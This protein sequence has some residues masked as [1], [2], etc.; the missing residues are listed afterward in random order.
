MQSESASILARARQVRSTWLEGSTSSRALTFPL[1]PDSSPEPE[2]I[3]EHVRPILPKATASLRAKQRRVKPVNAQPLAATI[4]P[5]AHKVA[6]RNAEI[7]THDEP[8]EEQVKR[9]TKDDKG[10]SRMA[11]ERPTDSTVLDDVFG[12]AETIDTLNLDRRRYRRSR[13][14]Q[15]ASTA[16]KACRYCRYAEPARAKLAEYC[17]GA[18]HS[19]LCTFEYPPKT[20]VRDM[21]AKTDAEKT[22]STVRNRF[23]KDKVPDPVPVTPIEVTT[24]STARRSGLTSM[25]LERW[26]YFE[27]LVKRPDK[28]TDRSCPYCRAS[29][30]VIR[31]ENA[32]Y[33]RG[34]IESKDCTF[35][36]HKGNLR[37][38]SKKSQPKEKVTP[39]QPTNPPTER[40]IIPKT[41]IERTTTPKTPTVPATGPDLTVN[42][43]KLDI[44]LYY[45]S[46][47]QSQLQNGYRF[48]PDCARSDD[49]E[50]RR[51]SYWC[52]GRISF[53]A[54]GYWDGDKTGHRQPGRHSTSGSK[55]KTAPSSRTLGTTKSEP[56]REINSTPTSDQRKHVTETDE[57]MPSRKRGRP[58]KSDVPISIRT[59]PGVPTM[60]VQ[61]TPVSNPTRLGTEQTAQTEPVKR[62]PGRP[63]KISLLESGQVPEPASEPIKRKPG[64][65][66]TSPPESQQAPIPQSEPIK[67]KLKF[68]RPMTVPPEETSTTSFGEKKRKRGRPRLSAPDTSSRHDDEISKRKPGGSEIH[69]TDADAGDDAE[70]DMVRDQ[71]VDI[72][73]RTPKVWPGWDKRNS[74]DKPRP[75]P[76]RKRSRTFDVV[77]PASRSTT[78]VPSP[79]FGIADG[80]DRH[81]YGPVLPVSAMR[82]TRITENSLPHRLDSDLGVRELDSLPP[83]SPPTSL[84]PSPSPQPIRYMPSGH[85]SSPLASVRQH[86]RSSSALSETSMPIRGILRQSSEAG[87]APRKRARVSFSL[88]RSPSPAEESEDSDV[89]SDSSDDILLL[90]DPSSASRRSAPPSSRRNGSSSPFGAEARFAE[91]PQAGRL[92]SSTLAAYARPL[93]RPPPIF[94]H[95]SGSNYTPPQAPRTLASNR[96]SLPTPPI[97]SRSVP[98]SSSRGLMRPPPVPEYR[99]APVPQSE[100]R[101]RV[102]IQRARTAV[103]ASRSRSSPTS[104][105]SAFQQPAKKLVAENI[106]IRRLID[107][108]R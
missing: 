55:V 100:P 63:R 11:G 2:I 4:V 35:D 46:L 83:S 30:D 3:A 79:T 1:S 67:L 15:K 82:N 40:A 104:S 98:P 94:G 80:R 45:T 36:G 42:E 25:G 65:P 58:R 44:K 54:C 52:R 7:E 53:K 14:R 6:R 57:A 107:D 26:R 33:Y 24:P 47:I 78:P 88:I 39:S 13:Y 37:R 59:E 106:V 75:I 29:E 31:V 101:P 28:Q 77:V 87:D 92:S 76:R 105:K 108:V 95:A 66:R 18:N 49:H 86:H 17:R 12:P 8:R 61:T 43:T 51:L 27:N 16:F 50:R 72:P 90:V 22:T 85:R 32:T 97:I 38:S 69:H 64:R 89:D 56:P 71:E 5:T 99:L 9:K 81:L 48:C 103:P 10:K 62:K 91:S 19:K 70:I 20:L 60:I 93:D 102:A 23:W 41:P 34:R 84:S 73:V 74:N 68:S 21:D 96:S